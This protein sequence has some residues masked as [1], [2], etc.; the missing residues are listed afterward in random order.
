MVVLRVFPR[1]TELTPDDELAFVGDPPLWMPP[2][3]EVHVSCTFT[4]DIP[5]ARR[6]VDAW[7]QYYPVVR[8]GGP[9]IGD[10]PNG[11]E[12][13]QYVRQGVT[14]TSRGCNNR[15]LFCLVPEREGRLRE[16]ERI[17]PGYIINDNNFL[18]CS[19]FHRG[20]VY[21][22][23]ARQP[24]AAIF[25]GGIQAS[26]VD[27]EIAAELRDVRIKELFLAADTAAAL[28][29]VSRAVDRLHWLGRRKLR[30]Y[31]LIGY[32]GETLEQAEQRLEA[33]WQAGVLPFAQLYQPAEGL[34][35]YPREW[36]D[37]A[38]TWSRPAVTFA[39]HAEEAKG[40]RQQEQ[41][42]G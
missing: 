2:A 32:N 12:P 15:C 14:F 13:G 38:R 37:L 6:L 40:G 9:A 39:S 1:R 21:Q 16:Y 3:D 20:K 25:A 10:K 11:F 24:R 33:L 18:Q 4:W 36:R 34:I 41:F 35:D 26:L 42:R 30:C 27:A 5:E 23:L 8:L 31:V 29:A 22:M 28:G 7:R 19:P 17:A